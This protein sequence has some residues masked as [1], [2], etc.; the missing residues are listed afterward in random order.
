MLVSQCNSATKTMFHV[1]QVHPLWPQQINIGETASSVNGKD[2]N[3]KIVAQ[4]MIP[5]PKPYVL[6]EPMPKQGSNN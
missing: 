1:L 4:F 3:L 2:C 5:F 6:V